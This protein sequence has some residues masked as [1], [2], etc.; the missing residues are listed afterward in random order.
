MSGL[1]FVKIKSNHAAP[2]IEQAKIK[3]KSDTTIF[4]QLLCPSNIQ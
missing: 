4:F 1:S 3:I 2:A